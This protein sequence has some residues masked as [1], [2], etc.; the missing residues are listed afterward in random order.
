[1]ELAIDDVDR[2]VTGDST[3]IS[4]RITPNWRAMYSELIRAEMAQI[5]R[6]LIVKYRLVMDNSRR[7]STGP[8]SANHHINGHCQ[9]IAEFT[10]HDFEEVKMTAKWRCLKRGWG[11][12]HTLDGD[13]FPKSE[14]KASVE[15]AC[16]LVEEL[17]Q[18]AAEIP[19]CVLIETP[20]AAAWERLLK[21]R[22][23]ERRDVTAEIPLE[24]QA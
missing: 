17:H 23:E 9:Q 11:L 12:K 21:T 19:G 14:S 10:G 8:G 1:M 5:K 20:Y 13:P 18:M 2:V 15:E 16:M 6:G 4:F 22:T 7:R 24:K 3:L